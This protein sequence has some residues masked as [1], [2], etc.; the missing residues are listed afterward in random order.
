M[1]IKGGH[2]SMLDRLSEVVGS[3][4]PHLSNNKGSDLRWRVLLASCFHPSVTVGVGDNLE[5]NVGDILLNLGVFKL[6][7]NQSARSAHP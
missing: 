6:S 7:S 1:I 2:T 4:V 3:S 5:G